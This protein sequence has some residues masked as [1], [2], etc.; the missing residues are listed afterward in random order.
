MH[1]SQGIS[2]SFELLFQFFEDMIN[3]EQLINEKFDTYFKKKYQTL[4]YQKK[5]LIFL[6]L[7]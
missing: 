5:L 7:K 3:T 4:S 2:S 6:L 1:N